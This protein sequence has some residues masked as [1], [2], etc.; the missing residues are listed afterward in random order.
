MKKYA[1][2]IIL[3]LKKAFDVCSHEILIR[4]LHKLVISD[5]SLSWLRS[6]LCSITGYALSRGIH[7]IHSDIYF[8]TLTGIRNG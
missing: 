7:R 6:Y 4:K 5:S 8:E 2:G 3:D 1:L